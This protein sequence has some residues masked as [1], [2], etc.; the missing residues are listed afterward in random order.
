METDLTYSPLFDGVRSLIRRLFNEDPLHSTNPN[1]HSQTP[2]ANLPKDNKIQD[3]KIKLNTVIHS[4]RQKYKGESIC[5][6]IHQRR[7]T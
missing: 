1:L 4:L 2:K 5:S 7:L 3:Y 6:L